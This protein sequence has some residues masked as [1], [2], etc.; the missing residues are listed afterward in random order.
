MGLIYTISRYTI[1]KEDAAIGIVLSLF[2]GLGIALLSYIQRTA[3]SPPGR[4]EHYLF[5][6]IAFLRET[7]LFIISL[8]GLIV[9]SLLLVFWKQL[10]LVS[11]DQ[12]YA[13]TLGLKTVIYDFLVLVLVVVT[14]VIS[15]DLIGVIMVA[16]LLIAP[17]LAARQW[18]DVF[19]RVVLL[20]GI[21]GAASGLL[22][23]LFS[24]SV[25]NLPAGPT[26][27]VIMGVI[28]MFSLL[29]AKNGILFSQLT[30]LWYELTID[31]EQRLE[32][33]AEH[34][35]V[36]PR[37]CDIREFDLADH[38]PPL[39]DHRLDQDLS[40]LIQLGYITPREGGYWILTLKG[41]MMVQKM[42]PQLVQERVIS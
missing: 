24:A 37:A 18:S 8:L 15:S 29:V 1:V 27:I 25:S 26:I 14:I 40:V 33:L 36:N 12:D 28:V 17:G 39:R 38:D 23:A 6:N 41:L 42:K 35:L 10:K 34:M 2:F 31:V 30:T 21:F 5:G 7:D 4:L 22:G 3:T 19:G 32:H 9:I 13:M 11:F 16:G 20:A